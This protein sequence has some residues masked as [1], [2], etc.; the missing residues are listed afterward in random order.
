MPYVSA[1]ITGLNWGTAQRRYRNEKWMLL[2][3]SVEE[4]SPQTS[5]YSFMREVIGYDLAAFFQRHSDIL[6]AEVNNVLTKLLSTK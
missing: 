5:I 2:T 1:L 3:G 4:E 6:K